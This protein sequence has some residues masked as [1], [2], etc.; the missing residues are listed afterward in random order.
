M[1][2]LNRFHIAQQR[3]TSGYAQARQEMSDGKKTGHWIWYILPQ[4][5]IFGFSSSSQTYGIASFEEACEYL[6]DER[7]FNNYHEIIKLIEEQL[8]SK[9]NLRLDQLMGE[10]DVKLL[11]SLTLF[12]KAAS[13]LNSQEENRKHDFKD[14]E[15]R[16]NHIFTMVAK[17]NY[18][19]CMQTES[20][21]EFHMP[22][23]PKS[24][25]QS[26]PPNSIKT[27][28]DVRP[29]ISLFDT[30]VVP[31]QPSPRKSPVRH[32]KSSQDKSLVTSPKKILDKP[33]TRV[34]ITPVEDTELFQELSPLIPILE[35]YIEMRRN[36][37]SFH[38]NFLGI[39]SL[40]YL[41]MDS[42]SGT[43]HFHEKSRDVIANL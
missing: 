24:S 5:N 25:V 21:L 22:R 15:N 18:Y 4:L 29:K 11:S 34:L 3:K 31:I 10:D 42:I 39:V 19:P 32:T 12:R 37:W 27:T 1:P 13:F 40:I 9:P 20:Y 8:S 26:E 38:Y 23:V 2:N 43:D 7:L 17:H 30:P 33:S 41:I 16:C 6:R 14:L 28:P 35:R 36:E